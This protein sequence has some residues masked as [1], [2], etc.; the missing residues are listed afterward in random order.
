[1]QMYGVQHLSIACWRLEAVEKHSCKL[2]VVLHY[3]C[4]PVKALLHYCCHAVFNMQS[5]NSRL[6]TLALRHPVFAIERAWVDRRNV[7]VTTQCNTHRQCPYMDTH[8]S[9]L[10]NT[11]TQRAHVCWLGSLPV[12]RAPAGWYAGIIPL[13]HYYDQNY[14][15]IIGQLHSVALWHSYYGASLLHKAGMLTNIIISKISAVYIAVAWWI[16][17]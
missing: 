6:H 4:L 3:C 13:C 12:P 1:M 8:M 9:L 2:N 7:G 10:C 5:T 14:A 16:I 11:R 15:S 17:F